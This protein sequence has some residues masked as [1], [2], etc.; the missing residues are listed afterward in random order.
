MPTISQMENRLIET[1]VSGVIA[2]ARNILAGRRGRNGNRLGESIYQY[3]SEIDDRDESS[4]VS[5]KITDDKRGA[6]D[7]TSLEAIQKAS[8]ELFLKNTHARGIIRDYVKYTIGSGMIYMPIEMSMAAMKSAQK[9]WK[10]WCRENKWIQAEKEI[11]RRVMR[12][13]ECFI[14]WYD[15]AKNLAFR[16]K[17][18]LN[19]KDKQGKISFGITTKRGDVE[20]PKLY[21]LV[22]N[23]GNQITPVPA[24]KMIHIK[25]NVDSDVKRGMPVLYAATMR[26]R[27]YDTWLED[28]VILTKIR[29]AIALLRK[30]KGGSASDISTFADADKTSTGKDSQGNTVRR[31]RI[32]GGTMMDVGAGIEYEFLSPNIDAR[33][34][35]TVGRQILLSIAACLGFPE[36]LVTAD[37][38]NANYASTTVAEGAGVMEFKDWQTFFGVGGFRDVWWMV[39]RWAVKRRKANRGILR[40][41][42]EVKG[43]RVQSRQKILDEAK[44]DE[45]HL[46]NQILSPQTYAARW[47]LDYE[48]EQENIRQFAEDFEGMPPV[49]S[50]DEGGEGDEGGGEP[51]GSENF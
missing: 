32:H 45:I 11:V 27:R 17:N 34:T 13:G 50:P 8:R 30:H 21:H 40:G 23:D 3:D 24:E 2:D 14:Q 15:S 18:P 48:R 33:D 37:T 20:S 9:E 26:I 19:V 51:D 4:W 22:N 43:Q 44:A 5:T 47:E 10:R 6:V 49:K 42:V 35:A 46:T 12:D 38:S 28:L 39:M 25:A 36:Y 16:F 41:D 31:R 7:D 1:Y 29:T